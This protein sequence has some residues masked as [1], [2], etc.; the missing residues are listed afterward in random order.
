MAKFIERQ[1]EIGTEYHCAPCDVLL[2]PE[3]NSAEHLIPNGIGGQKKIRNVLC[4]DRNSRT[5][6]EW[7][8][9]VTRQLNSLNLILAVKRDRGSVQAQDFTTASGK[10]MRIHADGHLTYA[11]EAPV[12]TQTDNGKQVHMR[13]G[14]ME[15]AKTFLQGQK[16][17]YPQLD[18]EAILPNLKIERTYGYEPLLMEQS[19]GGP[20]AGRSY[21]KSALVLAV[22]SGARSAD[23]KEAR[24]Y[25]FSSEGPPCFDFYY[26]RDVVTNR[27]ADK[28]FHCLAV[29]GDPLTR[30]LIGYVEIFRTWR[31]MVCLSSE[32]EGAAFE[33]SYAVDPTTGHELDLTYD[34]NFTREE[35]HDACYSL[36]NYYDEML[37]AH[38]AMMAIGYPASLE[39]ERERVMQRAFV[40]A[41]ESVGVSPGE[42]LP[43]ERRE[44]FVNILIREIIPCLE[45]Q[46]SLANA[47]RRRA[48]PAL[49]ADEKI[50][51]LAEAN[52]GRS[53][54]GA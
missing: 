28:I 52:G 29:K 43:E 44:E 34:L 5:G 35:L 45:H 40:T 31:M 51:E 39:R 33:N 50:S 9:D 16:R 6:M 38:R 4:V 17:K 25:L 26:K 2:T 10:T 27:P 49:T 12:M 46:I 22:A 7:D 42:V 54:E 32:Y 30:Q 47:S 23:C 48:M 14:T 19:T 41:M 11:P 37:Q 15:Q 53:G 20:M 8:A 13:V 21:V 18:V 1:V 24:G 3:N 36:A